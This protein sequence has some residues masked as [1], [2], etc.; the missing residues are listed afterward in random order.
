MRSLK[1]L[2]PALLLLS[3]WALCSSF[4]SPSPWP[5]TPPAESPAA[6]TTP[7]RP[8]ALTPEEWAALAVGID[9]LLLR[10]VCRWETRGER[11][12][13]VADLAVG[14][15]GQARGR[16]Q[17]QAGTAAY[18]M[19]LTAKDL[20]PQI[21]AVIQTMLHDRDVNALF[22]GLEMRWCLDNRRNNERAVGCYQGGRWST[23]RGP[24]RGTKN[25]M[26]AFAA[27]KLRGQST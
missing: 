1:T 2:L 3:S 13:G 15:D 4:Y 16:C 20:T 22:A 12:R 27:A 24:T 21:V 17:V 23:W 26:A 6:T 18:L 11:V 7:S 5:V 14:D 8:V 10:A 19:G 25:V 9:P